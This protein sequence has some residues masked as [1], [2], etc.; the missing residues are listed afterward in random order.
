MLIKLSKNK[1]RIGGF[2]SI[3]FMEIHMDSCENS[4]KF[5]SAY[6]V[7]ANWQVQGDERTV[8]YY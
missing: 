4:R 8:C 3:A 5:N 7:S 2:S 6:S 1:F